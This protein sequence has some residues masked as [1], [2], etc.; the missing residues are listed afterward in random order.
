[1]ALPPGRSEDDTEVALV[2]GKV[3]RHKGKPVS[4]SLRNDAWAD[5]YLDRGPV[6]LPP[7][8]SGPVV[9]AGHSSDPARDSLRVAVAEAQAQAQALREAVGQAEAILENCREL[10]DALRAI[11]TYP[12]AY[13]WEKDLCHLSERPASTVAHPSVSP[14]AATHTSAAPGRRAS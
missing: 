14:S 7:A 5:V 11:L 13:G 9:G 10:L 4:E 3:E 2:E 1:L 8:G 12:S 6:P